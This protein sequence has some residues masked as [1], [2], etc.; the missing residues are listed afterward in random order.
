MDFINSVL[1]NPKVKDEEDGMSK[2]EK[3]IQKMTE[4][5]EKTANIAEQ[6][7]VLNEAKNAE[8][9]VEEEEPKPLEDEPKD[10]EKP[11]KEESTKE[12]E[13]PN[14]E[15]PAEGESTKE[16]KPKEEEEPKEEEPK[17]G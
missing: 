2:L 10:D 14:E 9:V 5:S 3:N 8:P 6:L 1:G 13:K 16:E 12:E 15:K 7:K 11:A 17:K 4:L